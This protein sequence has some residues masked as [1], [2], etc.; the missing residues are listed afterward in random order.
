[1][2]LSGHMTGYGQIGRSN[3]HPTLA[4]PPE[5]RLLAAAS[6]GPRRA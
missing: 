3:G 1:L 6:N 5:Y 4:R 2:T